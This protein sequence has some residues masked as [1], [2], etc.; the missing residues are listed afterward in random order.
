[1][2]DEVRRLLD[3]LDQRRALGD[4]AVRLHVSV[5]VG[6]D[7]PQLQR[8]H[9]QLARDPVH[10]RLQREVADRH[11]EAAHGARRRAVRVHALG[12]HVDVRDRVRPGHVRG[13]LGR[14]VWAVARVGAGVGVQRTCRATIRPSFITPSLM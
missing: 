8:V 6:V 2:P 11:A 4:L 3:H 5:A 9:V 1:M 13:G 10:L 12:V 7:Q 14:G